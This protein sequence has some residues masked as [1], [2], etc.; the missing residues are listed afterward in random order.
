MNLLCSVSTLVCRKRGRILCLFEDKIRIW[1]ENEYC[2]HARMTLI[3]C[4]KI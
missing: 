3:S 2:I 1:F 4:V